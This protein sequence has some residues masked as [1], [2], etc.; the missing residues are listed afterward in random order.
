MKEIPTS[1]VPSHM[2]TEHSPQGICDICGHPY[3]G[4]AL[5]CACTGSPT[6]QLL[7]RSL[8]KRVL[9]KPN[10][11]RPWNCLVLHYQDGT[12]RNLS[13]V[14]WGLVAVGLL[15]IWG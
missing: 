13:W 7:K 14:F 2:V 3:V 1:F 12:K 5:D 15:W 6:R 9:W 11:V 8:I 4:M 10:G